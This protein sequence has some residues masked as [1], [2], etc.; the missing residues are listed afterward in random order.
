M[1]SPL[2]GRFSFLRSSFSRLLGGFILVILIVASASVLSSGVY[3]RNLEREVRRN[4]RERLDNLITGFDWKVAE[5]Q[6]ELIRI[7]RSPTFGTVVKGVNPSSYSVALLSSEM[8]NAIQVRDASFREM[9]LL[10]AD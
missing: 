5:I 3:V 8:R 1:R 7:Y 2:I 4:A 10:L 9:F 6:K